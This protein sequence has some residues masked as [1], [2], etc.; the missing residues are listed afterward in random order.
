MSAS[1]A[2]DRVQPPA[3][4]DGVAISVAALL[5]RLAHLLSLR[6]LP[7]FTHYVMDEAYHDAWARRIASGDWLG[8]P[9]AF[10]RA[11]L[12]PYLLGLV[13]RLFGTGGTAP[14]VAQI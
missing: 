3:W 8:G 10:F 5:L 7:T 13:Y 2:S 6:P 11:P 12:Y 9:E 4:A 14:R 1:R